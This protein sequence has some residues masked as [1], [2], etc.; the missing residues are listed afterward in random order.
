MGR[1]RVDVAPVPGVDQQLGLLLSMLD[2]G[3]REWREELNDIPQEAITWQP[4]EQGHSIG[5]V[6][7]HIADVEAFWIQEIAAQQKLSDDML[8]LFM[9]EDIKQDEVKWPTPPNK[10]IE[11]YWDLCDNVR[12]RTH[13]LVHEIAD[14]MAWSA[15][16]DGREF[17]LRWLMHHVITHEAY[18]GGQ[19]VLLSLM[20]GKTR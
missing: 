13:E 16:P 2:D 8:R 5:G 9:T 12:Q 19:V 6:I 10:P 11:W 1:N 7:L 15:S 4:F 3:T 20:H 18:H 17:T 14:P